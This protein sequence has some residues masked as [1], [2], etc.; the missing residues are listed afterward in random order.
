MSHL[1]NHH[2]GGA[3]EY[4][5]ALVAD[6]VLGLEAAALLAIARLDGF[7][8]LEGGVGSRQHGCW[9]RGGHMQRALGQ[10]GDVVAMADDAGMQGAVLAIGVADIDGG[11][12]VATRPGPFGLDHQHRAWA[13]AQQLP[14][15][16]GENGLLQWVVRQVLLDHQATALGLLHGDDGLVRVVLPGLLGGDL[17]ALLGQAALQ[18]C[19]QGTVIAFL[20]TDQ[21]VQVRLGDSRYQFCPLECEAFGVLR[22]HHHQNATDRLHGRLPENE[23][24]LSH[25]RCVAGGGSLT[26]I[27]GVL[28]ACS[29][30]RIMA[31]HFPPRQHRERFNHDVK[32][33]ACSE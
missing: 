17:E 7:L 10:A 28:V 12:N 14:V 23:W 16:G 19:K 27:K 22:I 21:Q 18:V 1:R 32:C 5:Q 2:V 15:L 31:R 20:V 9:V 4:V 8:E 25:Y 33:P 24:R 6:V 29:V 11:E 3:F 26:C 13:V 30:T